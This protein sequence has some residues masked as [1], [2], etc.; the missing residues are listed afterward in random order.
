MFG[1]LGMWELLV[2][3][4]IALVIMGPEKFPEF[5]KTAMKTFRELRG[6]WDEARHEITKELR[7]VQDEMRQ[8]SQHRPEDYIDSLMG[9]EDDEDDT[10]DPY[11][12]SNHDY[13]HDEFDYSEDQGG[14]YGEYADT[15]GG[16]EDGVDAAEP[17]SSAEMTGEGASQEPERAED[18]AAE[19]AGDDAPSSDDPTPD[20]PERMDG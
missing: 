18:A 2:I 15:Y 20:F 11:Y 19:D 1:N 6:F 16:G 17:E 4:G 3:G 8:I 12:D 5:V 13:N 10:E 14:E 7:P 9:D